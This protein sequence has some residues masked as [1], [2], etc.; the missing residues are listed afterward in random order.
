[1]AKANSSAP[2]QVRGIPE[3]IALKFGALI[4]HID[5]VECTTVCVVEALLGRRHDPDRMLA[6]CIERNIADELSRI[7]L[8]A[9]AL[10]LE[11]GHKPPTH[12][13]S[14]PVLGTRIRPTREDLGES[15][16]GRKVS[17]E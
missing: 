16:S 17:H 15:R 13:V 7:S 9:A 12:E 5:V 14:S 8:S 4:R 10:M 6:I 2:K 11:L 1:M 3:E